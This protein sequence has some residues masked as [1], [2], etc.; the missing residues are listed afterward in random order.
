[1]SS[2]LTFLF[3]R[4]SKLIVKIAAIFDFRSEQIKLFLIYKS[5]KILPNKFWVNGLSVQEKVKNR[6]LS[7][8]RGHLR[9]AIG[10]ILAIFHHYDTSY[11]VSSQLAFRFRRRSEKQIFNR[12]AKRPSWISHRNDFS[13]FSSTSQPD[14]SYQVFRQ[15]AFRFKRRGR[16][17]IFK[18]ATMAAI[19][20]FP[21]SNTLAIFCIHKSP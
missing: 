7:G 12:A 8:H 3:R 17:Q 5:P 18:V 16:K 13:Y 10:T 6:F 1:M 9:F 19:L 21:S 14:A 15:L 20:D 2:Q 4:N 11:Q